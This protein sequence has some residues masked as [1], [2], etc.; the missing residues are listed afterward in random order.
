M[1][2][3]PVHTVEVPLGDGSDESM[4]VQIREVDETLVRVGRGGRSVVRAER[5]FAQML[6]SV[7]PVAESF[8]GRFRGLANAPDEITLEFGV[9]LSAEADVVIASTAT[10]A[11]FSVTLTWNRNEAAASGGDPSPER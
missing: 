9:S 3:G 5:S 8:V 6:D 7:R 4:R 10:A 2:D 11:N 1:S